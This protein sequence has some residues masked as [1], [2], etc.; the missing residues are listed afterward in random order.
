[1]SISNQLLSS[2]LRRK[3][4]WEARC[5]NAAKLSNCWLAAEHPVTQIESHVRNL[6]P[7][8]KITNH[9]KTTMQKQP[10]KNNQAKTTKQKQQSES[11]QA[12][13]TKQA[14]KEQL[15]AVNSLDANFTLW[16]FEDTSGWGEI[17]EKA[18]KD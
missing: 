3:P 8:K 16:H 15:V 13:T 9:A 11:N 2:Y 10:C 7:T 12:K 5:L 14:M 17:A 18:R 4:T 6:S 1:M